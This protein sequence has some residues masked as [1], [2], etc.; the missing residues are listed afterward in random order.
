MSTEIEAITVG[1]S[2][3]LVKIHPTAVFAILG[4]YNRRP[5]DTNKLRV[6]GALLGVSKDGIVE[7]TDSFTVPVEESI[8]NLKVTI[9]QGYYQKMYSHHRRVN[10]KETIVGWYSTSAPNGAL[11][12][13]TTSFIHNFFRQQIKQPIH[14]VVDTTMLSG[15][16][17]IRGFI[18]QPLKV[19]DNDAFANMFH[20]TKVQIEMSEGETS[21]LFHMV[22]GNAPST[23]SSSSKTQLVST[24]TS[25]E[26]KIRASMEKLLEVLDSLQTYVDD[27]V[28]GKKDA[29]PSIGMML[30][31]ALAEINCPAED[32][33][34]L[35]KD[36][37]QDLLAVSYLVA[38][39]QTQTKLSE[40]LNCIL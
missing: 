1:R 22:A 13:D 38:L 19:G 6:I 39:F 32:L 11:I 33:Q 7:V 12:I 26:E 15:N 9:D 35:F 5:A 14:I 18:G 34:S 3:P 28:D 24:C 8:G 16:I 27:V 29:L 23:H 20:E 31:D 30:S 25:D 4:A 40:R 10:S 21:C 37:K 2:L 17:A 36:K